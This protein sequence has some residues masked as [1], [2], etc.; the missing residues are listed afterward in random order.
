[1]SSLWWFC[2]EWQRCTITWDLSLG[3][4]CLRQFLSLTPLGMP[5]LVLALDLSEVAWE[6]MGRRFSDPAL[7]MCRATYVKPCV[8][9]FFFLTLL[10]VSFVLTL[11]WYEQI[12]RYFSDPQ[13]Y[14]QVNDQYVRNKLKIVLLPFLHRVRGR[15]T[16]F[17]CTLS[18]LFFCSVSYQFCC[19][20][21]DTGLESQSQLGVDFHTSP[22]YMIL[23]HQ[24]YTFH[25][26]HLA[27][28]LFLLVCH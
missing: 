12:T 10:G 23:M 6:L 26:W 2:V 17:C 21:R 27:H 19:N 22:R 18:S 3:C 16:L 28:T 7:S 15:L 24:T 13:Y 14:F 8:F 1:M 20:I 25:L 11:V 5:S 9:S 4:L